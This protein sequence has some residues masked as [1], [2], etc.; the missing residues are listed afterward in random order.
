MIDLLLCI[1]I[2]V[3]LPQQTW[4]PK[5]NKLLHEM[6][7]DKAL[8]AIVTANQVSIHIHATDFDAGP[9]ITHA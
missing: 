2:A 3:P 1:I 6:T 9:L 4:S 8:I 5:A 7:K